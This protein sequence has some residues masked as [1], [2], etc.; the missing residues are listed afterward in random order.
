MT[1]IESPMYFE[2]NLNHA[3]FSIVYFILKFLHDKTCIFISEIFEK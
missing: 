1:G 2:S 3:Y